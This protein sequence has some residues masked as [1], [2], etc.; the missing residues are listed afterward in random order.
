MSTVQS[1]INLLGF[2]T[3]EG[4]LSEADLMFS[5]QMYSNGHLMLVCYPKTYLSDA[6]AV[7]SGQ[8]MTT[9]IEDLYAELEATVNDARVAGTLTLESPGSSMTKVKVVGRYFKSAPPV[10]ASGKGWL[11]APAYDPADAFS[12]AFAAYPG[13]TEAV[14]KY[15]TQNCEGPPHG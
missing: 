6:V 5:V 4:I 9:G 3:H 2:Y 8:A 7:V 11:A 10:R 15:L 14:F 12:G 13:V 1:L